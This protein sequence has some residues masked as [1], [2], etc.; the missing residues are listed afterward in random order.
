MTA[1]RRSSGSFSDSCLIRNNTIT[2]NH[3]PDCYLRD[4][5][6]SW[7]KAIKEDQNKGSG[8]AVPYRLLIEEEEKEGGICTKRNERKEGKRVIQLR[9]TD[10]LGRLRTHTTLAQTQKRL[11]GI[12]NWRPL[13]LS[14]RPEATLSRIDRAFISHAGFRLLRPRISPCCSFEVFIYHTKSI[15]CCNKG[16][17]SRGL[18]W[19]AKSDPIK[20]LIPVIVCAVW[21]LLCFQWRSPER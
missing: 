6:R 9:E 3:S 19:K 2:R 16:K 5:K 15:L 21:I 10:W 20:E 4:W 1:A 18:E 14:L 7:W 12:L 13:V 11:G 8:R 17:T